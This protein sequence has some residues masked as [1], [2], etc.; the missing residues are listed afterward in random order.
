MAVASA[1]TV[2]TLF[3]QF[4][5]RARSLAATIKTKKKNQDLER[6]CCVNTFGYVHTAIEYRELQEKGESNLF[7]PDQTFNNFRAYGFV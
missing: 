7:C 1:A 5:T 6:C 2:L 3:R 4:R